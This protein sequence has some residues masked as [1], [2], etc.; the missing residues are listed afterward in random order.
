MSML[1][2]CL[3]HSLIKKKEKLPKS[4]WPDKFTTFID[5]KLT[6][7]QSYLALDD[8]VYN[9]VKKLM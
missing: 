3:K 4:G 1:L 6:N 7:I 8:N 9:G 2:K 5:S